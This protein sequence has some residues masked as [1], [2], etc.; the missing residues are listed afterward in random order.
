[1][2][3]EQVVNNAQDGHLP[4]G[5]EAS[6]ELRSHL[7][8]C[9]SE[10]LFNSPWHCLEEAFDCGGIALQDI[11]GREDIGSLEAQVRGFRYS[12]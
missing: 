11:V 6:H 9:A 4:D 1:M 12:N 7:S 2:S 10:S 5:N 8:I 3:V